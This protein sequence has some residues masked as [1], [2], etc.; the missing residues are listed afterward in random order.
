MRC[1]LERSLTFPGLEAE[2]SPKLRT[3]RPR[4][5]TLKTQDGA[6]SVNAQFL[7][8]S[9]REPSCSCFGVDHAKK[10]VWAQVVPI[11]VSDEADLVIVEGAT[12][13]SADESAKLGHLTHRRNSIRDSSGILRWPQSWCGPVAIDLCRVSYGNG[14][15]VH[16]D[17]LDLIFQRGA[18]W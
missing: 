17:P 11:L 10:E 3:C 4:A 7:G 2:S 9:K 15:N 14:I 13:H 8:A 18:R 1:H 12:R 5:P 6:V 16:I